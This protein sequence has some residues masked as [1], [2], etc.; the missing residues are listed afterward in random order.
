MNNLFLTD[1]EGRTEE[2]LTRGRDRT[3]EDWY[4]P[5]QLE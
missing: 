5:A 3:T 4:F 2:M 1:R